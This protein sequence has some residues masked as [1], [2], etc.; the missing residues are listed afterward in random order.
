MRTVEETGRKG[1]RYEEIEMQ[2]IGHQLHG[3]SEWRQ[4]PQSWMRQ[5]WW[6]R[7]EVELMVSSVDF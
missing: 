7:S 3:C 4:L 5:H 1:I 2:T 6:K